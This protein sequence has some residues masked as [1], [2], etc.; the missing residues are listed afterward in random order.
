MNTTNNPFLH[1]LKKQAM[2]LYNLS[3]IDLLK[4]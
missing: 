3:N 1:I 2:Y 4:W